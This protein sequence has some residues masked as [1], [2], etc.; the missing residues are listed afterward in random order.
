MQNTLKDLN[1][2]VVNDSLVNIDREKFY[3]LEVRLVDKD[4][5]LTDN[6]TM[7]MDEDE[8]IAMYKKLVS[9]HSY[10]MYCQ[11]NFKSFSVQLTKK[12]RKALFRT[13][14]MRTVE[15]DLQFNLRLDEDGM[16][17]SVNAW[18]DEESYKEL[19]DHRKLKMA[20]KRESFLSDLFS[21][22]RL[23][24]NVHNRLLTE[25]AWSVACNIDY[26]DKYMSARFYRTVEIWFNE[27]KCLAV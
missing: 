9:S 13:E 3:V 11:F 24:D 25:K 26:D 5:E 22:S 12:V 18:F 4:V 15:H 20:E 19:D 2:Y 6:E 10:G 14:E 16:V 17:K 27:L 1:D 8:F 23:K 7:V 21:D